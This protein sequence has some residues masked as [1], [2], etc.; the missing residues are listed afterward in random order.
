MKSIITS[1]SEFKHKSDNTRQLRN[2]PS[3]KNGRYCNVLTDS[4]LLLV[5]VLAISLSYELSKKR[6]T[7][8]FKIF[9]TYCTTYQNQCDN[10]TE[11]TKNMFSI[12][13]RVKQGKIWEKGKCMV[14]EVAY[15]SKIFDLI[16]SFLSNRSL[17]VVPDGKSSQEY[18]VNAG[19]LQGSILGPTLFLPYINE[20]PDNIICNIA[21]YAD[22]TTLY[23]KCDRATDLWQQPELASE[24]ESDSRDTVDWG[25]KWLV[26]FNAGTTELVS[27]EW[28]HNI[29]AIDVKMN[30]SV[31]DEKSSFKI[32]VLTSLAN[33]IGA[34]A[35][36]TS[37]KIGAFIRSMK[38]LLPEIALYLYKSTIRLCMEYCCH[39]WAAALGCL[40]AG[41]VG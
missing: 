29:G 20:L 40:L 39:V 37:K 7:R 11:L 25:R 5:F 30:G 33:W 27:F 16:S 13:I 12:T 36:T 18:P 19:V 8:S 41:T 4:F 22:D 31:L 9:V 24:L 6:M 28:S 26:D 21:I 38:F 2:S 17:Q 14:N 15:S 32:L 1:G 23:S 10:K 3:Q 34:F 35:K